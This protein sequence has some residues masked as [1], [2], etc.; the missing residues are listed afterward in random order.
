MVGEEGGV[1]WGGLCQSWRERSRL[2]REALERRNLKLAEQVLR[3]S[4]RSP[5]LGKDFAKRCPS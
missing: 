4:E 3:S 5:E 1:K 2:P